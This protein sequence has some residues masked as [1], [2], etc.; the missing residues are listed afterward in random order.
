MFM[1]SDQHILIKSVFGYS[2]GLLKVYNVDVFLQQWT[3]PVTVGS[4]VGCMRKNKN[5]WYT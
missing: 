4:S 2:V 3:T 5:R 1:T